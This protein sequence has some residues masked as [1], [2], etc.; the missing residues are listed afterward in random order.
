MSK[1]TKK[2]A[3][4]SI[5]N[6]AEFLATMILKWNDLDE[7]GMIQEFRISQDFFITLKNPPESIKFNLK[8]EC[9]ED[10][11]VIEVHRCGGE[12]CE[13]SD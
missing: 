10:Q 9:L 4:A 2:M 13:E 11:I 1:L 8:S 3:E 6:T 7:E 5:K 12:A